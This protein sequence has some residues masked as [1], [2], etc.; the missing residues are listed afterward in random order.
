M[1]SKMKR[2]KQSIGL[3]MLYVIIL[4][5]VANDAWLY[6]TPVVKITSVQTKEEGKVK[7]TRG[8]EEMQYKQIIKGKLLNG[9]KR[10]K[11]IALSN[12]YAESEVTTQHYR[13]G[14]KILVTDSY[15]GIKTRKRDTHFVALFGMLVL[16]LIGISGRKGVLT[17]GT[18]LFNGIIFSIGFYCLTFEKDILWICNIMA[19]LFSVGTLLCLN[20]WNRK[21]FAAIVSTIC[22]LIMI[23]GMFDFIVSHTAELDYS[24]MEYLG[25]VEYPE[26]IFR[27]QVM[28][29]GLGA[30]MDVAV[31]ISSGLGEIIYKTPTVTFRQLFHSGREIGYDIMGT[32]MNVL[33]FV[34]GCGLIPAFLLQMNNG[35][36]MLTILRLHIPHEICKF[37][38]ESIGIVLAI[39]ISIFISSFFMKFHEME[40]LRRKKKC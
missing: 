1:F 15:S 20:G 14:D 19:F 12:A 26:T 5:L 18:I 28:F 3:L 39:P 33:L 31:T 25:S 13:K 30:I 38:V 2:I 11:Q 16:L 4:I 10:G 6:K 36:R 24:Q 27:V 29:A 9:E 21:T 40:R 23:M 22:V 35:V 8:T 17:I 37:L 7:G 34:F 32:M